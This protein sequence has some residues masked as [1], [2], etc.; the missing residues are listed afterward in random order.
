M[1]DAAANKFTPIVL[2]IVLATFIGWFFGLNLV[3]CDR[4]NVSVW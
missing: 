3:A 1:A 2:A 4:L